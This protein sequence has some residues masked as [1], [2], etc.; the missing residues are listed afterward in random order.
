MTSKL[1]KTLINS[2]KKNSKRRLLTFKTRFFYHRYSYSEIFDY[3]KKFITLL[4]KYNLKKGDKILISSYNC[5]QY[6]YSFVGS[7]FYGTIMVP[8][9]FHN[10]R[11]FIKKI[12]KET[13]AKLVISSEFKVLDLEDIEVLPVEGLDDMLKDLKP[14][15]PYFDIKDDDLLQIL[16][17]SGT[18][19]QPK[20]VLLTHENIYS[21]MI[22]VKKHIEIKP[23]FKFFFII[24]FIYIF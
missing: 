8:L 17:T 16:Y 3:A 15:A 20:G 10:S 6:I 4:K 12:I 5:P 24:L 21:N 11:Q 1:A 19:S 13:D 9:D 2:F 18:T 7:L 14:S 22:A 23:T